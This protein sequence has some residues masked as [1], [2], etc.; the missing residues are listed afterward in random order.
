MSGKAKENKKMNLKIVIA[1]VA[2]L[3]VIVIGALIAYN[4]FGSQANPQN[5]LEGYFTALYSET[6]I[7]NM[8]PYLVDDIRQMCY[9]DFTFY[10]TS[11]GIL[12]ACQQEKMAAVGGEFTLSVKV[13]KETSGSS[14]AL[15]AA[16]KSYGASALVDVDFTATFK[17]PDGS[18]DFTGIARLVK[19]SGKWY[20]TEYNLPLTE[21][22]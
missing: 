19:I 8:Q 13:D 20:L 14:T 18:A 2:V 5:T 3:L 21:K 4:M 6:R 22:K 16:R 15:K 12:Q 10:G 7:R 9:D 11:I 1:I 17:G